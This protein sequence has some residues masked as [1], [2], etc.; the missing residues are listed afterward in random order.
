MQIVNRMRKTLKHAMM[1]VVAMVALAGC[2]EEAPLPLAQIN[3][4]RIEGTLEEGGI[5][6]FKG[7]PYATAERFQPAHPVEAWDTVMLC[8]EYGPWARQAENEGK[9][10]EGKGDFD[11]LD[12]QFSL[13]PAEKIFGP[14]GIRVKT[15]GSAS[16]SMGMKHNF[17]DNPT[18]SEQARDQWTF[19]FNENVQLNMKGSYIGN[20]IFEADHLCKSF[21]DKKILDDFN[22][23]FSRYEKMGIIGMGNNPMVGATVACAVAVSEALKK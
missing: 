10:E 9:S 2:K 13:G 22:Y 5:Y 17:V 12:M 15:Q 20:K 18:L 14:G 1:A 16:L 6:A 21:G 3:T 23:I 4:G 8:K 7:I 11:L 19:D